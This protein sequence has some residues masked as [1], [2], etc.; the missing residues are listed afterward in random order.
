MGKKELL[1][2]FYKNPITGKIKRRLCADVGPENAMRVY[3]RMCKDLR[4]RLVHIE[5]DKRV[6]YS[7]YAEQSDLWSEG[8]D[9]YVQQGEDL[10]ERMA[11][12]FK[13]ARGDGYERIVLIGSDIPGLEA[14][15][16]VS[17]FEALDHTDVV[18]GPAFDGGYYLIGSRLDPSPL[19]TKMEW[20]H[21]KVFED[22]VYRIREQG[23]EHSELEVLR[24]VDRLSDLKEFPF[25]WD[26]VYGRTEESK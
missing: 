22:T 7:E 6:Y 10:G 24:D 3:R 25:L 1:I 19:M 20:S 13:E 23:W 11:N 26:I 21:E 8:F 5:V 4:D 16:I 9:Q 12:A 14:S 15:Q 18:I 17:A 2:V